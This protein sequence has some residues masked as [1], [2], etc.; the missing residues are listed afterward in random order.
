[1]RLIDGDELYE[2]ISDHVTTVSVCPTVDWAMGKSQMQKICL[3]DIANA[4][5]VY[6]WVSVKDRLPSD[7]GRYLVCNISYCNAS[8][9]VA[10]FSTCLENVGEYD[11][12]GE[13]RPGWFSYDD[14]Y[15]YYE[16]DGVTHWIPLP[17]LPKENDTDGNSKR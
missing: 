13:K 4:P 3:E 17:E 9:F 16:I 5:T 1:M 6:R 11:F 14:E 10:S 15:G 7:D 12:D 8:A 2:T